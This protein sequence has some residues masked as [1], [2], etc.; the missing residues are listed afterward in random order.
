MIGGRAEDGGG[1]AD[2]KKITF[3]FHL[4]LGG[5]YPLVTRHTEPY[6]IASAYVSNYIMVGHFFAQTSTSITFCA[7]LQ[8]YSP[9]RQGDYLA[10]CPPGAI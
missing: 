2:Y 7:P 4:S 1:G 5:L 9:K 10:M 6:N 8:P 3:T